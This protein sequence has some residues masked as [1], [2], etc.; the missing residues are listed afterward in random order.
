MARSRRIRRR[1]LLSALVVASA[2]ALRPLAAAAQPLP[3]LPQTVWELYLPEEYN[4][5][6]VMYGLYARLPEADR[7]KLHAGTKI[8]LDSSKLTRDQAG[9]VAAWF[10]SARWGCDSPA[11]K[12]DANAVRSATIVF[13]C[14]EDVVEF[15]LQ[16]PNQGIWKKLKRAIW[17]KLTIA[18]APARAEWV[19]DGVPLF[20]SWFSEAWQGGAHPPE[21]ERDPIHHDTTWHKWRQLRFAYRAYAELPANRLR[22]LHQQHELNLRFEELP[23][24]HQRGLANAWDEGLRLGCEVFGPPDVRHV[25]P[26]EAVKIRYGI[27]EVRFSYARG[28]PHCSVPLPQ[29]GTGLESFPRPYRVIYLQFNPL[30]YESAGPDDPTF[31]RLADMKHWTQVYV[32]AWPPEVQR[33]VLAWKV[34]TREWSAKWLVTTGQRQYTRPGAPPYPRSPW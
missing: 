12:L 10:N 20:P 30:Y 8:P 4:G 22:Q 13:R 25:R 19:R 9:V 18:C 5:C 7:A 27:T 31:P 11:E 29:G 17:K 15:C 32:I 14:E 28:H 33:K 34:R 1:L 23:L 16:S 24:A 2:L 3:R 26:P 21:P 6:G